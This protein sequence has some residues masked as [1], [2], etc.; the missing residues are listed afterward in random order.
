MSY[1]DIEVLV[2]TGLN[3]PL[4]GHDGLPFAFTHRLESVALLRILHRLGVSCGVIILMDKKEK[5]SQT[6]GSLIFA[7]LC[8]MFDQD[9]LSV[10]FKGKQIR[11]KHKTNCYSYRYYSMW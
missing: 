5:N 2:I 8:V 4:H 6:A 11:R 1:G 7:C 10:I 3:G 9:I